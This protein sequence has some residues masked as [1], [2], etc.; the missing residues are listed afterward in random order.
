MICHMGNMDSPIG[1]IVLAATDEGLVYCAS[2][3]ENGQDMVTW[4]KK[5]LP[6]YKLLEKDNK[7]LSDA[8]NQLEDYFKGNLNKLE[9]PML[10][11][12][13]DFRKTVWNALKNIPYGETRTYGQVASEIGKPKASRAVGQANHHNPISYFVP[14]HRVIGASGALVGFGGGLDA[15]RFLL[16]LEGILTKD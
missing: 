6:D 16:N 4:L 1:T 2:E 12:G 14:W 13:T 9:I 8:K 11:I 3:R 10:L 15:K 7:I 5:H